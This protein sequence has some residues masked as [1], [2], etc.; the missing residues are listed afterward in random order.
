VFR[1]REGS[2]LC[3]SCGQLVGVNDDR[4]LNCGRL[5]PGLFGF[6]HLLRSDSPDMGFTQLVFFVCGAVYLACLAAQPEAMSGLF[7]PGSGALRRFGSTGAYAVFVQGRWWTLLSAA[8][9]HAS[10]L[11]IAFNMMAVRDLVPLTAHLY[12]PARTVIIY[13]IAGIAGFGI[14][15][16]SVFLPVFSGGGPVVGASASIFGLI[17]ALLYY[18]RRGGSAMIGNAAKQ[19]AIGGL[20]FGFLVPGIDNWA[21]LG[22]LAGGYVA[23]RWLDP[24]MPE[25]GDHVLT[26]LLCLG[27]S[28]ASIVASVVTDLPVR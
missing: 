11:H 27:L 18:G 6:A 8:W 20:A 17:G 4:C 2:V 12:G 25:R 15:A 3:P 28:I 13:T 23:A 14:S 9:L 22:G 26:A 5:R 16:S 1:K 10:I 19:W 21:H 7:S 24:L